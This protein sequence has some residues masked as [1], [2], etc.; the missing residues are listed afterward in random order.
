MNKVGKEASVH[1]RDVWMYSKA[2]FFR[3]FGMQWVSSKNREARCMVDVARKT[4]ITN[5]YFV[6]FAI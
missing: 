5:Y 4:M 3:N 2:I 6:L 1:V